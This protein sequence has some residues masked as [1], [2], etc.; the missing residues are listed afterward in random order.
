MFEPY[1]ERAR[2]ALF[3]ARYEASELGTPLIDTEH[4]L[5]GLLRE[6][7][8]L[9]SQIL[10]GTGLSYTVVRREIGVAR[11]PLPA[12]VEIPFTNGAKLALRGAAAEAERL[13]HNYI[14]TEH[15]LLGLL[16]EGSGRAAVILI[17]HGLSCDRVRA[18][19]VRLLDISR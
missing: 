2:R 12:A 11:E 16:A 4:L 10:E 15:L 9:T 7:K 14:D 3:F 5:L 6:S 19:I 1:T 8:G 18:D 13:R 17:R